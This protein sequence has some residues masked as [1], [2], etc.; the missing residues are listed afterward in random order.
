MCPGVTIHAIGHA[1]C[2]WKVCIREGELRE[3]Q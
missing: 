1:Q 3:V 2:G